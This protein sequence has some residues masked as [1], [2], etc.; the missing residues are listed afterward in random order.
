MDWIYHYRNHDLPVYFNRQH[1]CTRLD[2]HSDIALLRRASMHPWKM[3]RP[4]QSFKEILL[5]TSH[6]SN[7]LD[8]ICILLVYLLKKLEKQLVRQ[9]SCNLLY[10]CAQQAIGLFFIYLIS[11]WQAKGV[12]QLLHFGCF[13][14]MLRTVAFL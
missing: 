14:W 9:S 6:S 13:F 10:L 8:H 11:R 2:H 1:Y 7:R 4:S 12:V 3:K 5:L